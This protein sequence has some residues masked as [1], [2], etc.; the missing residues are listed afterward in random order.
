M[1][2]VLGSEMKA[3]DQKISE[4]DVFGRWVVVDP[5]MVS[6]PGTVVVSCRCLCGVER[7]V[8]VRL[9]AKGRSKSCGCLAA[10]LSA[11]R[12]ITHGWSRTPEYQ[13]WRSMLKRCDNPNAKA[14]KDYGGRGI[15]IEERWYIFPNFICDM[16]KK[17]SPKHSIE[18]R[19]NSLGYSKS[20]C[21][22]AT[23]V[24]QN[25]NTRGNRPISYRGETLN[26]SQWADRV[27]IRRAA[28]QSRLRNGWDFE[29][30]ISI[31]IGSI[32]NMRNGGYKLLKGAL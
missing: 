26:I 19:D 6:Q 31:S 27:G 7:L 14:Y 12:K 13:A 11:E 1:A 29:D 30:A 28:L 9:L 21:Y 32:K 17:P 4:G 5:T 24:E 20:N 25:N 3:R 18:R 23:Y 10:D 16:G 22:W 8:S 2:F 15:K